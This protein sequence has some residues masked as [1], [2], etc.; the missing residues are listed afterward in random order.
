MSGLDVLKELHALDSSATVI[1]FTGAIAEMLEQQACELGASEF[2]AKGGSLR[3][4]GQ[5]LNLVV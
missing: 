5:V 3:P 4:L 1:V 2:V